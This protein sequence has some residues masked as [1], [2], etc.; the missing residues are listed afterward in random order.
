MQVRKRS[1][2]TL[3]EMLVAVGLTLMIMLMMTSVFQI[4]T[5]TMQTQKGLAENDQKARLLTNVLRNDMESRTFRNLYPYRM[6]ETDPN[7]PD[8]LQSFTYRRGYFY[9]SE[10]DPQDDTDDVLQFTIEIPDNQERLYG[11][12]D[13]LGSLTANPNQPDFDDQNSSA[14]ST[15]ASRWAEV[16]YWMRNGIIYRRIHLLRQPVSRN[17]PF[18][19][20]PH[21]GTNGATTELVTA[22]YNQSFW[23][24]FDYS[25]HQGAG[26]NPQFHGQ[27]WL[28]HNSVSSLGFPWFRAGFDGSGN[29]REYVRHDP[30]DPADLVFIGRFTHQETSS[31]A[32]RWPSN[33]ADSVNNVVYPNPMGPDPSPGTARIRFGSTQNL[34]PGATHDSHPPGVVQWQDD[35][36]NWNPYKGDRLAE[37]IMLANVHAFDIK[38]LDPN[39]EVGG[40]EG[41]PGEFMDIGHNVAGGAFAMGN[42]QLG[43]E[44]YGPRQPSQNRV[45]DTWTPQISAPHPAPFLLDD[46]GGNPIPLSAIRVTIRY[47][48]VT[49]EQMREMILTFRTVDDQQT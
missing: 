3:V 49:T 38:V 2:F 37:D 39:L 25:A 43:S 47:Q 19:D 31:D 18:L 11:R 46:A 41:F 34:P 13:Q 10:N 12:A 23:K 28:S 5:Q 21:S 9:I 7:L 40:D 4:T 15:G 42:R 6:N 24:N 22:A 35:N 33:L 29:P 48:D 26:G 20:E 30:A 27:D 17:P 16:S 1:G 8:D 32:F 45:F 44:V 14:N 36:G